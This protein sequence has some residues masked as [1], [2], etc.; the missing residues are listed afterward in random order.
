M[1]VDELIV[2]LGAGAVAFPEVMAVI[3]EC[4]IFTPTAFNNG[5]QYNEAN[6]NNGS[7]KIFA[8]AQMHN[9]DQQQTLNA[10]GDYYRVDVLGHPDA[11]DHANIRNFMVSGWA[12]I[13]FEGAALQPV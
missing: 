8:F 13:R 4:Y 1:T 7:C 11:S 3:D 9:L 12:G 10:F 2:R 5:S 6:T